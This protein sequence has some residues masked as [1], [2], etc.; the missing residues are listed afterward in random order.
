M[1]AVIDKAK[2]VVWGLGEN[3][4]LAM[5]DAKQE[6][7]KKQPHIQKCVG[8]LEFCEVPNSAP[9]QLCGETIFKFCK[10]EPKCKQQMELL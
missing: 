4:N 3:R 9:L 10:S 7:S 6:I 5:L 8:K 1:I 2:R